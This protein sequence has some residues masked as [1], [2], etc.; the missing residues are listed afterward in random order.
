MKA[1]STLSKT[2]INLSL[3]IASLLIV[4]IILEVTFIVYQAKQQPVGEP[5]YITNN[6]P[7]LYGM[8]PAS[9]R[10]NSFGLRDTEITLEN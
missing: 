1:L 2:L 3:S 8:N 10:V 7:Y 6:K 9:G 4:F 5:L